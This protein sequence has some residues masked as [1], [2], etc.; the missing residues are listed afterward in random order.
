MNFKN[1]LWFCF[2]AMIL[3]SCTKA[4]TALGDQRIAIFEDVNLHFNPTYQDLTDAGAD[5]I[6]RLDAGRVVLKKKN[7]LLMNYSRK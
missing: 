2:I 1:S 5:S 3:I 7:F 4:P 6:Y